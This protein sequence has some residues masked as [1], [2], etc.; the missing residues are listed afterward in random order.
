MCQYLIL[1][2][3]TS[4]ILMCQMMPDTRIISD[5][6]TC[7]TTSLLKWDFF[8][9]IYFIILIN[10]LLFT[11]LDFF[12]YLQLPENLIVDTDTFSYQPLIMLRSNP[13]TCDCNS[14][15]RFQVISFFLKTHIGL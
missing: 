15:K 2:T 12:Y 10:W 6:W 9:E 8:S 1:P 14:V 11:T 4:K 3:I 7:P 5:S 13:W